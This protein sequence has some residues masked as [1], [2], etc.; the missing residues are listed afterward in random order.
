MF[1]FM[2]YLIL[3]LLILFIAGF[4]LFYQYERGIVFTLG[5][6]SGMR[7]PGLRWIVPIIQNVRKVDIRIKTLDM[8]RQEMIT[9][10]NISC[11]LNAVVYYRITN[12]E[13]AVIKVENLELAVLQYT[14]TALRDVIGNSELDEVL[15]Q[16]EMV[17]DKIE[18]IVVHETAEWG[19]TIESIKIQDIELPQEMKRAIAKQAEAERERRA[20]IIAAEG[21]LTAAENLNRAA[22][23]LSQNPISVTLRTLQTIRDISTNPSQ[24]IVIFAPG[25]ESIDKAAAMSSS[26]N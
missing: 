20:N 4:K 5:K 6:Y 25:T 12:P 7:E 10:D 1:I 23:L 22:Q 2:F 18:E 8:P 13:D 14:Q 19:I 9:K 3:G 15:T 24:K 11:F 21:E 17:S 26:S 16:R